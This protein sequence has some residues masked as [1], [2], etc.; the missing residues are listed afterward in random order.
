MFIAILAVNH[1]SKRLP[2]VTWNTSTSRSANNQDQMFTEILKNTVI[3]K[4]L[5]ISPTSTIHY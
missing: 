1:S 5:V 4:H 2:N 3:L